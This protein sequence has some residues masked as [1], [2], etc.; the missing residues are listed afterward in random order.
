MSIVAQLREILQGEKDFKMNASVADDD[1][2][3]EVGVMD[4]FG[5]ITLVVLL[6]EK[7]SIKV[8]PEDVAQDDLSTI[9]N[10]VRF[11]KRRLDDGNRG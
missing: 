1:H 8:N 7:F 4:S 5:M 6:E 2:L 9:N 11:L 10:I 3:I